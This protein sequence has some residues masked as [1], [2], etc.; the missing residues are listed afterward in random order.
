MARN[1]FVLLLGTLLGIALGLFIGWYILPTEFVDAAPADLTPAEQTEYLKLVAAAHVRDNNLALA[2]ERLVALRRPDIL[3]W[4][5]EETIATILIGTDEEAAQDLVL[6]ATR[7]GL[8]SPVFAPY[9]PQ[10]PELPAVPTPT[11]AGG[12]G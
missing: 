1:F 6:L 9:L 3:N 7:L 4:I 12:N 11:P 2:Q 10:A 8:E 5:R